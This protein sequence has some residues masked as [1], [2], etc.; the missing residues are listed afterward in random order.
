MGAAA[1]AYSENTRSED[2]P[3]FSGCRNFSETSSSTFGCFR[4]P[5]P[6]TEP[7]GNRAKGS[8]SSD[9]SNGPSLAA[10]QG[11]PTLLRWP[12]PKNPLLPTS[13]T[14][15]GFKH[16]PKVSGAR[17]RNQPEIK[18]DPKL[19]LFPEIPLAQSFPL[20]TSAPSAN[21]SGRP[22]SR[23]RLRLFPSGLRLL[24]A[25]GTEKG[26]RTETRWVKGRDTGKG[27]GSRFPPG[28]PGGESVEGAIS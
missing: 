6:S 10:P 20:A 25:S 9:T 13:L 14:V 11:F 18:L 24:P 16:F 17:P 1:L 26:G 3:R 8:A 12:C 22:R 19:R 15:P 7:S 2:F 4:R 27:R 23:R 28:S 21:A 5:S